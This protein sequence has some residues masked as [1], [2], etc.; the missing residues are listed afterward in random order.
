MIGGEVSAT[1]G[2]IIGRYDRL[3]RSIQNGRRILLEQQQEL[4]NCQELE[5]EARTDYELAKA[6]A[7]IKAS[8]IDPLPGMQRPLA[9]LI[10][11]QAVKETIEDMKRYEAMKQLRRSASAAVSNTRSQLRTVEAQLSTL[12]AMANAYNRELRTLG[13]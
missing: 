4:E 8:Q 9:S 3:D 10:E 13:G 5:S 6:E 1:I 7:L 2:E 12:Q 11:A